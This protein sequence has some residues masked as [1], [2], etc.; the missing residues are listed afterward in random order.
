MIF[1]VEELRFSWH[2]KP[3]KYLSFTHSFLELLEDVTHQIEVIKRE[4]KRQRLDSQKQKSNINDNGDS[5]LVY[6]LC[7]Y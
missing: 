1:N 5:Q 2:V 4:R 7:S 6:G 3:Q